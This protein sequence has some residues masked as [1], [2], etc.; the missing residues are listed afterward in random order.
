MEVSAKDSE[1]VDS[2]F[3]KVFSSIMQNDKLKE[4]ILMENQS[5]KIRLSNAGNNKN[6]FRSYQG[7]TGDDD[8]CKC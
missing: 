6:S 7:G 5:E 1:S 4:R 2:V 3:K 8:G